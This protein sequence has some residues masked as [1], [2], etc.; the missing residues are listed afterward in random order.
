M[1]LYRDTAVMNQLPPRH[2]PG[3]GPLLALLMACLL[4]NWALLGALHHHDDGAMHDGCALCR[5]L[6]GS[7][8]AERTNP[9]LPAPAVYTDCLPPSLTCAVH[10]RVTN[11]SARP[12]AP[13]RPA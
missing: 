8:G 7:S 3:G 11:L 2:K 4:A 6:A 5:I 1:R 12:H 13:P 9:D 10:E